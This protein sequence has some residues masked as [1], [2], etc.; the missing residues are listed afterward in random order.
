MSLPHHLTVPNLMKTEMPISLMMLHT[1][2]VLIILI[3]PLISTPF[4]MLY[5]M[6]LIFLVDDLLFFE[7]ISSDLWTLL[8][9]SSTICSS[10]FIPCYVP[11]SL[12]LDIV[13]ASIVDCSI[14]SLLSSLECL[15]FI[16]IFPLLLF[17]CPCLLYR[18]NIDEN[19]CYCSFSINVIPFS[20][21]Y[22][23]LYI[24][25]PFNFLYFYIFD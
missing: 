20:V 8:M 19:L 6:K 12:I 5:S 9:S 18:R 15:F 7:L 14:V 16:S 11:P 4:S 13:M 24:V 3:F 21:V 23:Y 22:F 25:N 17:F 1:S 10:K 2:L